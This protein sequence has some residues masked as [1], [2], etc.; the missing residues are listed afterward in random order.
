MHPQ[1]A[2]VHSSSPFGTV[3]SGWFADADV[4]TDVH[5]Q[6]GSKQNRQ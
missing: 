5:V 1:G 3:A 6:L 2:E 4:V